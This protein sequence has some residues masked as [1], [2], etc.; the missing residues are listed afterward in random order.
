MAVQPVAVWA[1]ISTGGP[2]TSAAMPD[3]LD[4]HELNAK[5]AGIGAWVLMV[6]KMRRIEYEYTWQ[7]QPRKGQKVECRLVAADGVY[8]QGVIKAQCRSWS[9]GGGVDPAVELKEVQ[10]KFKDG[11]L[12]R[13]TKVVLANEKS[14]YIGSPLSICIDLHKTQCAGILQG[15]VEMA[16][17]PAPA[18]ELER[19]LALERTQRVDLTTLIADMSPTRRETTSYGQKDIVDVTFV[20]GSNQAGREEPVKA[21]MALFFE[22]SAK[23]CRGAQELAGRSC[24]EHSCGFVWIDMHPAGRGALRVQ[25]WP[26]LLL[27]SSSRH[28]C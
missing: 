25:S 24:V 8:C 1:R 16:P 28:L 15:S 21:Q 14:E 3:S 11:T 23:R 9:R 5:S 12:W 18:D 13:M 27:G 2:L 4:L 26:V 22:T 7:N 17:A 10:E 6:Y 20:D 19:I